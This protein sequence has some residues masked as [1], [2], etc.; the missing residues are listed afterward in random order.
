MISSSLGNAFFHL[1]SLQDLHVG[2]FHMFKTAKSLYTVM[3]DT[4]TSWAPHCFVNAACRINLIQT[5]DIS[6]IS[7]CKI[8]WIRNYVVV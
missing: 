8:F 7:V 5:P 6:L 1:R 4:V 3:V 2:K